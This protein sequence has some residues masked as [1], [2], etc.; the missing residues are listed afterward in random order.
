MY[1]LWWLC[2]EH[3]DFGIVEPLGGGTNFFISGSMRKPSLGKEL[4]LTGGMIPCTV[5]PCLQCRQLNSELLILFT[6]QFEEAAKVKL[7]LSHQ[8]ISIW[9]HHL[10]WSW[11]YY[12]RKCS[13]SIFL[14]GYPSLWISLMSAYVWDGEVHHL[15]I[16]IA[17]SG[18]LP[19][20]CRE[21]P[22]GMKAGL[23]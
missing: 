3:R 1:Y 4:W 12:D 20:S 11:R 17:S 18:L 15:E 7:Y 9:V 5:Y 8:I 10:N 19:E 6:R 14:S 23:P 2:I 22:L 16:Y 13:Y 21:R